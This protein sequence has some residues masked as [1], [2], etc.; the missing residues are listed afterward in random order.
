MLY[1]VF[2]TLILDGAGHFRMT[3]CDVVELNTVKDAEDV[4]SEDNGLLS[5][6]LKAQRMAQ[7]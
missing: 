2:L 6:V 1:G 4:Y 5:S 3:K 7:R